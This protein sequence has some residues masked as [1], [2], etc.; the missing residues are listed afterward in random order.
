M[1]IFVGM[2]VYTILQIRLGEHLL[3][4]TKITPGKWWKFLSLG[5]IS[6]IACL[7]AGSMAGYTILG[8]SVGIVIFILA[9]RENLINLYRF[10]LGVGVKF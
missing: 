5:N 10:I 9:E 8:A 6:A 7:L 3:N 2:S 1:A 4:D